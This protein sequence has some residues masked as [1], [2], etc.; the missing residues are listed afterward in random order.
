MTVP[1]IILGTFRPHNFGSNGC[2]KSLYSS[3]EQMIW[4]VTGDVHIDNIDY[5]MEICARSIII[6]ENFISIY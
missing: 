2:V 4:N 1:V 3:W 5:K 6:I